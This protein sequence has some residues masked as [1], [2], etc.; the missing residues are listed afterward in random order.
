MFSLP[1]IPLTS[2]PTQFYILSFSKYRQKTKHSKQKNNKG[3]KGEK[4][5]KQNA[6]KSPGTNKPA[7]QGSVLCLRSTRL[8]LLVWLSCLYPCLLRASGAPLTRVRFMS[9]WPCDV[10]AMVLCLVVLELQSQRR[11]HSLS[12]LFLCLGSRRKTV[13][14]VH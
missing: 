12:L 3:K 9:W 7:N 6:T 2:L 10:K 4:T 8:F 14:W 13:R 11:L 5:N 1:L